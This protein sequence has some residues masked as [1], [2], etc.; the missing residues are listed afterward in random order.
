MCSGADSEFSCTYSRPMQSV[1]PTL[2]C[3]LSCKC[4]CQL[5]AELT[6]CTSDFRL[7]NQSALA[8]ACQLS[9]SFSA[10]LPFPVNSPQSA[11]NQLARLQPVSTAAQCHLLCS[12][13]LPYVRPATVC[14]LSCS[15]SAQLQSFCSNVCCDSSVAVCQLSRIMPIRLQ[16][17][18][19]AQCSQLNCNLLACLL[20]ALRELACALSP[21]PFTHTLQ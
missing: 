19:S 7:G 21:D 1:S 11:C 5:A 3:Q 15:L 12:S 14:Q 16:F 10:W 18:S 20:A 2:A 17:V 13:A 9:C 8:A 4:S 6:D